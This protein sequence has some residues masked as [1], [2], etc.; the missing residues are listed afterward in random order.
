MGFQS[1]INDWVWI[2]QYPI[3]CY[4]LLIHCPFELKSTDMRPFADL[5]SFQELQD[6]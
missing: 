1:F 5:L 6:V 3:I 4:T 2:D